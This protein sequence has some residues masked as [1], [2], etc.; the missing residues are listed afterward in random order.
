MLPLICRLETRPAAE[1]VIERLHGRLVR[2]WD[3]PG[4]RIAVRF[5]DTAAQRA[6]RVSQCIS[7]PRKL[8]W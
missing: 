4:S 8:V 1:E 2:G 3:D 6:L 7:I 5:A